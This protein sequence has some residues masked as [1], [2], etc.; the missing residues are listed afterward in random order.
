[1]QQEIDLETTWYH[2]GRSSSSVMVMDCK[3]ANTQCVCIVPYHLFSFRGSVQGY[4]IH[5]DVEIVIFA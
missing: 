5:M 3:S 4:K 1:M 2:E